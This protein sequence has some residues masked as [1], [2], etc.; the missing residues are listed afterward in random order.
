MGRCHSCPC[1]NL[2]SSVGNFISVRY[3]YFKVFHS[4]ICRPTFVQ[5][6]PRSGSFLLNILPRGGGIFSL[7]TIVVIVWLSSAASSFLT[8][9]SFANTI[10]GGGLSSRAV[11]MVCRVVFLCE[12]ERSPR[13]VKIRLDQMEKASLGVYHVGGGADPFFF[14]P[15]TAPEP[16]TPKRHTCST[17][18]S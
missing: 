16:N 13:R 10:H 18:G 12:T 8:W 11:A 3:R 17:L 1:I 15:Q 2:A 7:S 5:G 9:S 6:K 4:F 14:R